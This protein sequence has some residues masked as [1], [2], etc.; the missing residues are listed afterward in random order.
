MSCSGSAATL[1][2]NLGPDTWAQDLN[3]WAK[4][5]ALGFL[6]AG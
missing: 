2:L 6:L 5:G 4:F 3:L 1:A